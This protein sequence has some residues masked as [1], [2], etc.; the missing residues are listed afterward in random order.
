MNIE[1][2]IRY[3][4]TPLAAAVLLAA[5][6]YWWADRRFT[7]TEKAIRSLVQTLVGQGDQTQLLLA[8]LN[9]AGVIKP[10]DWQRLA[11]AKD[12]VVSKPRS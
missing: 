4:N 11:E 7:R 8:L 1:A 2:L 10:E 3:L 12:A 6:V 5:A 9:R